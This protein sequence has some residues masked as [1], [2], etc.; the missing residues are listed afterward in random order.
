MRNTHGTVES[1]R[2]IVFEE[3]AR[4]AYD[5]R[6]LKDLDN[7]PYELLPGNVAQYRD[8]VL[9]ERQIIGERLRLA[10]GLPLRQSDRYEPLSEG[11]EEAEIHEKYYTPPLVN[12]IPYACNACP[13][14]KVVVTSNCQGCVDHPCRSVCPKK[15]ISADKNGKSVIDESVCIKCGKCIEVCPYGAIG[16]LERPC[17]KA[18]G[19]DAISSDEF[20]RAKINYDLCV[21]CGQCMTSCPFGAISDK[22]QIYQLVKSIMANDKVIAIVAPA[23][24][25]QF[26]GC[27]P[28]KFK[29]A[30]KELGFID[31]IEVSIGADLCTVE[32]GKDFIE[33]VPAEQPFMGTSCCPSW[34]VMAKRF[35]GDQANCI[36]MTLTPMV[37]T[38]RLVKKEHP[39]AK[40]AFIGPC[41]AKKLEASR[42]SVKSEVDFVLTFEELNGMFSAKNID[43]SKMETDKDDEICTGT[44]AGRGFAVSGGVAQAVKDYI[45]KIRPD[46]EVNVECADGLKNCK[47]MLLMAKAGKRN[48]YLLE[49]MACPGGCIAGGGTITP[50]TQSL[51]NVEAYK[52]A[53]EYA[54]ADESPYLDGEAK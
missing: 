31:T 44:G 16:K 26:T 43:F 53:A 27:T 14:K 40:I 36:S 24:I 42:K 48:G 6:G 11:V 47:K 19:M 18:C 52:N 23:Y 1:I 50:V 5:N 54:G 8:S 39:D 34:S 7:L 3:I 9:R 4:I 41:V 45:S 30:M 37:I 51:K 38:A 29:K 25:G 17:A 28:P 22:S 12:V 35:L 33:K 20:G 15:A 21:S 46:M 32:E 2:K 10:C 49:G 13:E